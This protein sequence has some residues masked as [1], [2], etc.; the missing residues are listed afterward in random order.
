ML[1]YQKT[2]YTKKKAEE[3]DNVNESLEFLPT[4]FNYIQFS[5]T[6]YSGESESCHHV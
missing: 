1:V 4:S 2:K 6:I 3:R 5:D